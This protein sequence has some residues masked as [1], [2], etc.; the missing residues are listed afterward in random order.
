MLDVPQVT[1][2][3]AAVMKNVFETQ[4]G[5]MIEA[6]QLDMG[7]STD[8]LKHNPIIL[9]ADAAGVMARRI[10]QQKIKAEAS[11]SGLAIAAE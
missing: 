11:G 8:F 5:P 2:M 9:K 1:E 3:A 7:D 4:D 10:M 6:Q